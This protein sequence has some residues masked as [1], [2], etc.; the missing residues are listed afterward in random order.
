MS[1]LFLQLVV[2]NCYLIPFSPKSNPQQKAQLL[3][4]VSKIHFPID[5]QKSLFCR[6][7]WRISQH[8]L[9]PKQTWGSNCCFPFNEGFKT[10]FSK[11]KNLKSCYPHPDSIYSGDHCRA[12]P[13]FKNFPSSVFKFPVFCKNFWST[14]PE[15]K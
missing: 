2:L 14:D 13:E 4:N 3:H 7:E 8:D 1:W 5:F 11:K 15:Q 6:K 10:P 12:F 9:D